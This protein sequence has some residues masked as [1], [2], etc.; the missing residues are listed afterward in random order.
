MSADGAV[1]ADGQAVA[2]A[3]SRRFAQIAHVTTPIAKST[4]TAELPR[5]SRPED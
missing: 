5:P 2:A 1:T 3:D 4:N